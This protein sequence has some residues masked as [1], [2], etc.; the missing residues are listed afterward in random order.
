MIAVYQLVVIPNQ[1]QTRFTASLAQLPCR[2]SHH[3]QFLCQ[4]L[5]ERET[6]AYS[7][8]LIPIK[9]ISVQSFWAASRKIVDQLWLKLVRNMKDQSIT[10]IH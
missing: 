9:A 10:Y 1:Y 3:I 8:A 5:Y 6:H 4:Q 7:C 2:N